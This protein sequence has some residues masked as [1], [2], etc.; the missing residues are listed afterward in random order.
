M[1]TKLSQNDALWCEPVTS[2]N[3]LKEESLDSLNRGPIRLQDRG[4]TNSRAIKDSPLDQG[5]KKRHL[6]RGVLEVVSKTL[7]L[8]NSKGTKPFVDSGLHGW[9]QAESRSRKLNPQVSI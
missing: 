4:A 2:C 8:K 1:R 9:S 7:S 3:V 5:V 6:S